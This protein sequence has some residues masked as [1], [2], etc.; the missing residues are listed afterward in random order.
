MENIIPET[1]RCKPVKLFKK[2]SFIDMYEGLQSL[3]S[4]EIFCDIKLE[5]DDNK[6]ITAHKVVLSAACPYFHAMFTNF[7]ERNHDLVEMR[8]ID[9]SALLLLVNFIY[10]GQILITEENVQDILPAADILQ[11]QGVKEACCDFLQSQLCPTNCIEI[12]AFADLYN[13]TNLITTSEV[14]I[15][16]HFSEVVGGKE[17]LSLSS[18][19]VVKLISSDRLPVSSEEK[20]FESVISWV[21]Y[22]LGTRQCI[23]LKLMEHV[24]LPLTSKNFILKYVLKEPLIKNC[25]KC[26]QYVFEA[27]N[28]LNSEELVPQTIQN[29][30]R[31]GERVILV[32]GGID[33]GLSNT[34]EWFDTRTNQWHFGPELITNHRRHSLVVINN[35]FVF[36]VGGYVHGLTPYRCVHV[37]DL[38][39]ESLSWQ[40]IDDMLIERQFLGVGVINNNIYAVGGFND[41]DGDLQSAEV[42][43]YN[44][45]TWQMIPNMSTL[46]SFFAVGVLNDLLYVVGGYDQSRQALDTVECYNPS[47]DMWSPVA[48]MCVCRSGAGVGVLYGEL[49][50]VGGSN[51]SD[52]LKSVEKYSPRTGVWTPIADLHLP[53]KYAEVVALDGLLYAIGGM[54]DS[55]LLD[56]VERYNPNT[57]TWA[58]VTAKWNIMR[59]TPGVVA[60][61]RPRHFTSCYL[62]KIRECHLPLQRPTQFK[63]IHTQFTMQNINQLPESRRCEAVKLYE[64]LSFSDIYEGLQSLWNGEIFCDIKL[65]TDDKKIITAHKVVLSAASP[66]FHAMFTNFA[67]RNH[68]LVEMR[69]IDYS[70]LLLLVNFL[71]SGKILITEENVQDLLPAADILQLQ[72]VKEACCDFL[73]SQLCSTNC[74]GIN[75]IADLHSCTKLMT[76]SEIYINQ[77][78]SE[79]FGGDEFLLLSSEQ[80]IKLISSDRLPVSS[81]EKVFES[82]IRWVKYDLSSRNSI[83]PQLM[84]HVRLP[85]TSKD[86]I[87]KNVAEE[88]LIKNCLKSY[89]YVLKALN[90][91]E[92]EE[93]VPQS[94][95]NKPRHGEKVILVVGGINFGLRHSLEWFDTRTNLWNLG[96]ELITNHRRHGLV[97]IN[98]NFVFV[99]GGY[100]N[101]TSPYRSVCV[102]DLSAETLCWKPRNDMLVERKM[103]GVGVI[104]NNIYAVGGYNDIDGHCRSAEIFDYNTKAWS[105]VCSMTTTRSLFAVGVLNDLL[106]VVGGHDQETHALDTVECYNPSIDMW[107]PV[108]NMCV[109]R[110]CAGVGVLYGELYAVG[111]LN[112]SNLLSSVEKYSPRTRNWTTVADLLL[113]RKYAEVV[114][115]D[116]LLYVIGGTNESSLLDSVEC[117]NPNTNTWATV[118]AKWNVARFSPG[119]VAINRPQRFTSC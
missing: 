82:V 50:A 1:S 117:Y 115:L 24:R 43:D 80:V 56:F 27:L 35:N 94:I 6:I 71:Y 29:T 42:F 52:L 59:F 62:D 57:N 99:V 13:C 108:A 76:S 26:Y 3:R 92:S 60:I 118:T 38:T 48:N 93:L 32:V 78:F 16:Q 53:R 107:R 90:T 15:H 55:S 73:Q 61:N 30:P 33:S 54:G 89:H 109:P 58:T 69:H 98:D 25:F 87:I 17:F 110:S 113:P 47:N 64:K 8:H 65:E 14:Y 81:D 7:A 66:Y 86:Y 5:T 20:V 104:N 22:D 51:G 102:L 18:E 119:V 31:H 36:D 40:L 45:Q 37:L 74:I 116:G 49:Y 101:C 70:A 11:L 21:K 114:A 105:M 4:D 34:L 2:S 97:V 106:Y 67:E 77:H 95:W 72:G 88:P 28:T 100:V 84:E 63:G 23:L 9:Y 12:N 103:L 46:R 68:D 111:G 112:G 83:L 91:L 39:S 41:I 44:T 96:P 85:L 79:V 10:S 19:Q 75:S